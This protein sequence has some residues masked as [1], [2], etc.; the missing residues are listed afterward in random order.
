MRNECGRNWPKLHPTPNGRAVD[1]ISRRGFLKAASVV[2]SGLVLGF[3]VPGGS[4]M[5]QAAD[6][7]KKITPNAF[8]RIAPDDTITVVVNRLEFGQGVATSLPMLIAE[9]LGADWAQMRAELAPGGAIFNDPA[10]GIQITG[11]KSVQLPGRC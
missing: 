1:E 11:A 3:F 4:K 10:F 6:K 8:L 5:A 2:G 9:E 7:E